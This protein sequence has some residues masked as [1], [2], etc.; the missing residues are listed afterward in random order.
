MG[1]GYCHASK[2]RFGR[3]RG[4]TACC[5]CDVDQGHNAKRFSRHARRNRRYVHGDDHDGSANR[6]HAGNV[7]ARKEFGRTSGE[8]YESLLPGRWRNSRCDV[9]G[10]DRRK[11]PDRRSYR[12]RRRCNE[13]GDQQ[14]SRFHHHRTGADSRVRNIPVIGTATPQ[15]C[16]GR[17]RQN[18]S[19]SSPAGPDRNSS[20][21]TRTTTQ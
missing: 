12:R 17:S 2:N 8:M 3:A 6:F 16:T 19:C 9:R 7:L 11:H 14:V 20:A 4:L 21:P 1:L 18:P 13:R 10:Y 15:R 5:V